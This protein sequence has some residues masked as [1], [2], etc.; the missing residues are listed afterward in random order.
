MTKDSAHAHKVI[1]FA[2]VED[3]MVISQSNFASKRKAK[4]CNINVVD[5]KG[6]LIHAG[7]TD[8]RG[9]YSFKIPEN[10]DTELVLNLDAGQ[11]HKAYW[12]LS[13]DEL[14]TEPLRDDIKKTMAVKEKLQQK[15][16]VYKI[17]AGVGII[18]LLA[19]FLKLFN[20]KRYK[21]SD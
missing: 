20:K 6:R 13:A 19:F 12:K 18:F 2:W 8:D 17:A 16:S 1:I 14:Q 10:I 21:N 9:N 4:N 3:G 5:G 15:P 7:K 11:G